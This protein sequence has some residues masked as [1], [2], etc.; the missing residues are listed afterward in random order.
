MLKI[1]TK[2]YDDCTIGRLEYGDFRCVTVE[3]PWLGN[4]KNISCIPAGTYEAEKY[5]SPKHGN[6]V[7]FK[8]VV[9][10]SM[11]EIHAG[12]YTR[13]IQ[14]CIL[15]GKSLT[16]LDDDTILDV[17]SSKDTLNKLMSNLPDQFTVQIMRT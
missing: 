2:S 3:L 10:R 13:Q 1:D 5:Q 14:G 17:T 12:N 7:L 6:V 4:E 8:N 16:Y 9:S 15:V 11:I